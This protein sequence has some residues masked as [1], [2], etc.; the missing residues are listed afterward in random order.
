MRLNL[1]LYFFVSLRAVFSFDCFCYAH[2]LLEWWTLCGRRLLLQQYCD[3][4]LSRFFI[5]VLPNFLHCHNLMD[6]SRNKSNFSDRWFYYAAVENSGGWEWWH[7]RNVFS[8][9]RIIWINELDFGGTSKQFN[10]ECAR[11]L[12]Y[13]HWT[14]LLVK[15]MYMYMYT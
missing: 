14:K 3:S 2:L 13:S 6:A 11:Y 4:T 8:V 12:K 5:G 1:L 9:Q 7:T 10:D 15:Y